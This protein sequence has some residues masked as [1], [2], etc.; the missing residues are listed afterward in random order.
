VCRD[1]TAGVLLA[2]ASCPH[3]TQAAQQETECSK[4]G[5]RCRTVRD[6]FYVTS[7]IALGLGVPMYVYFRKALPRIEALPLDSWR[8]KNFHRQA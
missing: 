7:Y 1:P 5:G 3:N 2:E 4:F 8:S 6:G